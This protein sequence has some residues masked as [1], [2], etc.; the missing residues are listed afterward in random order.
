[1]NGPA[2]VNN[3]LKVE[4]KEIR[5][6]V[7]VPNVMNSKAEIRKVIEKV[8]AMDASYSPEGMIEKDI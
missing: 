7:E 1:V 5:D 2:R 6:G 4:D 8:G 3:M